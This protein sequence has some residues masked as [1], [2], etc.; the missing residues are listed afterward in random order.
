MAQDPNVFIRVLNLDIARGIQLPPGSRILFD[1]PN[2]DHLNSLTV[3]TCEE[4]AT[5]S[6]IDWNDAK[7]KFGQLWADVVE[8]GPSV[9][10]PPRP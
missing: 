1:R 6:I 7:E 5:I 8:N 9:Y 4:S 3:G 2:V 10:D